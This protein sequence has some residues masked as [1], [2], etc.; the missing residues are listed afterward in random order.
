MFL[1]N[2][3]EMN[4][5][6]NEGSSCKWSVFFS[7]EIYP[8]K[9]LEPKNQISMLTLLAK[10]RG[11]PSRQTKVVVNLVVLDHRPSED[12]PVLLPIAPTSV[13]ED[14]N[15]D[16]IIAKIAAQFQDG[17]S[18]SYIK[19]KI[20]SG[21]KDSV[22]K[23][24]L[25]T[26]M[27]IYGAVLILAKPLDREVKSRYNLQILAYDERNR[28][29]N[30]TGNF[31]IDVT[32]V[33]DNEPKFVGDPYRANLSNAT[34]VDKLILRVD[35]NDPD[36]IQ[37]AK[38]TYKIT[39]G[40]PI[41]YFDI[42]DH[43]WIRLRK[44]LDMEVGKTIKLTISVSDSIHTSL[45]SVYLSV[46]KEDMDAP[47]FTKAEYNFAFFEGRAEG[48]AFNLKAFNGYQQDVEG[49]RY[50]FEDEKEIVDKMRKIFYIHPY[51]GQVDFL[52]SP[53]FEE[54]SNYSF[55][56]KAINMLNQTDIAK[57]N[58]V[59]RSVDEFKPV[60]LQSYKFTVRAEREEG[61]EVGQVVATDQD[62]GPDGVVIYKF[63][64]PSSNFR[65]DPYTGKIYINQ[66]LTDNKE[67]LPK[68]DQSS[69]TSIPYPPLLVEASSGTANSLHKIQNVEIIIDITNTPGLLPSPPG[70]E[71]NPISGIIIAV[72]VATIVMFLVVA[73]IAT[74]AC[75]FNSTNNRARQASLSGSPT[76]ESI[77]F[78]NMNNV[79][80]SST[81]NGGYPSI[82]MNL[83]VNPSH[84][85]NGSS[86]RG[87]AINDGDSEIRLIT[88]RNY[89]K[90]AK[91]PDFLSYQK[92]SGFTDGVDN[93]SMD[94]VANI[95]E[96]IYAE[97]EPHV[98]AS[99]SIED[100]HPFADEAGRTG[101]S[102]L[103]YSK[104]HEIG[105]D[106]FEPQKAF[107][108]SFN[109]LVG[110]ELHNS[111]NWDHLLN[112]NPQYHQ[113]AQVFADIAKLKDDNSSDHSPGALPE[114]HPHYFTTLA[115]QKPCGSGAAGGGMPGAG[116]HRAGSHCSQH[117][118]PSSKKATP[119]PFLSMVQPGRDVHPGNPNAGIVSGHPH[120]RHGYPM[121]S[122]MRNNNNSHPNSSM[123][124]QQQPNFA[125]HGSNDLSNSALGGQKGGPP[126][127]GKRKNNYSNASLTGSTS[128][129]STV[130]ATNM[131]ANHKSMS[132][133]NN[134][135]MG[136]S[137][138]TAARN[139][140][141]NSATSRNYVSE[142]SEH[143]V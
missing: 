81:P 43:G 56:V 8:H 78:S 65:I 122:P 13:P 15:V 16:S 95:A 75:V 119:P 118:T 140:P 62:K 115:N 104:L 70:G 64:E 61:T 18:S 134:L 63:S 137:G 121:P 47:V 36:E 120:S 28:N 20:I 21:N 26:T 3:S 51:N 59:V 67:W 1:R 96:V 57:V 41:K 133:Q 72:I 11:E 71:K 138:A 126:G 82:Q 135:A 44:K 38:L 92:D 90:N 2:D 9:K 69:A 139:R 73:G 124:H 54:S 79:S 50:L 127:G 112:W 89:L 128:S 45:A 5:E 14:R 97:D 80:P 131:P 12:S 93:V 141:T 23:L 53:D 108:G 110:Q 52:Q 32:D 123:Q 24:V 109:S 111:Y 130:S 29:L 7:G 46:L 39:T 25:G 74:L 98:Y 105:A 101:M 58:V 91:V 142:H 68:N 84:L 117:A 19:Y 60:F 40:D 6:L 114:P 34:A 49:F 88:E 116:P 94:S 4:F 42:D 83:Q 27:N 86:G 55:H 85:S 66:S 106:Q 77:N 30:S 76:R 22:F 48:F 143:P 125:A 35:A 33:N 103:I 87:S 31:T 102:S 129:G 132:K 17:A 136:V 113:L 37:N 100:V 99:A 107:Q 10:D